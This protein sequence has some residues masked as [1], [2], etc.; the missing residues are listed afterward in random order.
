MTPQVQRCGDNADETRSRF[1]PTLSI[2][3]CEVPVWLIHMTLDFRGE[4]KIGV[5]QGKAFEQGC[6]FEYR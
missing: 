4:W 1:H 6:A 2:L 3:R 5:Q